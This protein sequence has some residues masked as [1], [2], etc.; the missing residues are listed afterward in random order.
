MALDGLQGISA[1]DQAAQTARIYAGTTISHLGEPLLQAGLALANQG[2]IDYQALTRAVSTGTHGTGVTYGSYSTMVTAVRMMLASGE[3]LF[4]SADIEPEI[5]KA[6]QLGLGALGVL[7]EIV[8]QLVAAYRLHQRTWVA[9]FEETIAQLEH[10][11]QMNDHFEFFWLPR[12]DGSVMK[13]LTLT[14]EASFGGGAAAPAPV[15]TL[16][17]YRVPERVDWSYRIYPSER[18]VPFVE[19][20]AIPDSSPRPSVARGAITP[21]GL[22]QTLA[23]LIPEQAIVSDE[24][25]SYGRGFYQ[26][27]HAAPP[28]DW[29]QLTGGAIGD[30]LPVATGAALGGGGQRR[31]I[32]LQAD[33]SAMYSLQT[34]WTQAHERLPLTPCNAQYR[35]FVTFSGA[36]FPH[37]VL[38]WCERITKFAAVRE[39]A[40]YL[41]FRFHYLEIGA[42]MAT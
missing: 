2:D 34:L 7:T 15:G 13:S 35:F 9:S 10:Q 41:L 22:A 4:C 30:G 12:Y 19:D 31:V 23:A 37:S 39:V 24:S 32:S 21:E 5:F 16:E 36:D 26:Y 27:T 25:L 38:M 42:D 17:R 11:V 6:A 28:H 8:L 33:G 40:R 18:Q 1:V 20:V 29:L 14:D 3:M